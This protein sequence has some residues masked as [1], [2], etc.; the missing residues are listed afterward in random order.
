MVH[1]WMLGPMPEAKH[2]LIAIVELIQHN[3]RT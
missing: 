3:G 2:A 1:D